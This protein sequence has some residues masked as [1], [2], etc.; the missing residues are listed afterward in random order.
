MRLP[1]SN[2]RLPMVLACNFSSLAHSQEIKV[3]PYAALTAEQAVRQGN[4]LLKDGHPQAALEAYAHARKL[5][6]EAPEI[7]FSEGLAHYAG[8]D[9]ER[10][11]EAF[12]K[13]SGA[14]NK[15]LANDALYSLA[16]CDHAEALKEGQEPKSAIHK[17]ESAMQQYHEVLSRDSKHE[18]AREANAKAAALWRQFKQQIQQQEQQQS[19]DKE[20]KDKQEDESKNEEKKEGEQQQ[21]EKDSSEQQDGQEKQAEQQES[22]KNE[23]QDPSSKQKKDEAQ[24]KEPQQS[25]EENQDAQAAQEKPSDKMEEASREQAKRKLREMMQTVQ[26]RK[27]AKPEQV[28]RVVPVP[29]DKDW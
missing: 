13:A 1:I 21:N 28:Q 15:S 2:F 26:Q 16:A 6:P 25:T 9:L 4:K 27:K 11:R 20:N 19:C 12:F 23:K 14:R 7:A 17:L 18:A 24:K 22:P 8:Q 10:A 3:D 29:V 5:A